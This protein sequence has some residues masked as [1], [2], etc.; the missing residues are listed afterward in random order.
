VMQWKWKAWLH[1]PQ[2]TL[3]SSVVAEAPWL[4]WHSMPEVILTYTNP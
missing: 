4:A 3:H 2:A 1:T